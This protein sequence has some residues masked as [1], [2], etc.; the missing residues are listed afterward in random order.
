LAKE[1]E[2]TIASTKENNNTLQTKE[3]KELGVVMLVL[4]DFPS[5]QYNFWAMKGWVIDYYIQRIN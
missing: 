2:Q 3:E 5:N 4:N 1:D